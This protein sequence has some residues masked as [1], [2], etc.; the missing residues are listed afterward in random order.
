MSRMYFLCIVSDGSFFIAIFFSASTYRYSLHKVNKG[1]LL[2]ISFAILESTT[3][4]DI[5]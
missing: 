3:V 2:C 1:R 5:N 4:S